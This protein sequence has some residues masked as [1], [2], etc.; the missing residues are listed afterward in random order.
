M[1]IKTLSIECLRNIT[2]IC[3]E[4][5][6]HAN[7]FYGEN[8][9]GKTS[10]L[11]AVDL[12]SNGRTFRTRYTKPLIKN[13]E[14]T[15]KIQA[16]L[17]NSTHI[18][19]KKTLKGTSATKNNKPIAKQSQ[20]SEIV[21]A[22]SIHPDNHNLIQ[23]PQNTR[24]KFMDKGVFHVKHEFYPVWRAYHKLLKQRNYLLS[25]SFGTQKNLRKQTQ[26]WENAMVN[27]A[28]QMDEMRKNYIQ[29]LAFHIKEIIAESDSIPLKVSY[30]R[31][32]NHKSPLSECLE[33]SWDRDCKRG[34]THVGPHCAELNLLWEDLPAADRASRGQQK[35]IT[36]IL[37]LAQVK[38]FCDRKDKK[39]ILLIDDIYAE[40]DSEHLDWTLKQLRGLKAQFFITKTDSNCPKKIPWDNAGMFHVKHGSVH[41]VN[42]Q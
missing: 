11:E 6:P 13:G 41:S 14:N 29:G 19:I 7:F 40:L 31:G 37:V 15:L 23:G 20:L 27:V 28:N 24:R 34:Y 26:E 36:I 3:I 21:P 32:W 39:G 4:L 12:V 30:Y 35:I 5:N 1:V 8:G 22:W 38:M 10:V 18:T 17:H 33:S 2:N 9:A 25:H 42:K 16:L